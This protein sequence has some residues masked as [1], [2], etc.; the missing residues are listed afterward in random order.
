[1]S[2]TKERLATILKQAIIAYIYELDQQDYDTDSDIYT[3]LLN[4]FRMTDDEF[5][6]IMGCSFEQYR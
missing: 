5:V 1:M 4:E 2:I 3:V 6:N